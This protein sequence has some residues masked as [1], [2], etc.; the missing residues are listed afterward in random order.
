MCIRD[1]YQRRVRDTF[2]SSMARQL[3][4]IIDV[5]DLTG[6]VAIITGA[7]RGIGREVALALAQRGCNIVV[8]AKTT[9]PQPTLPG[10]IYS[11]AAEV[12]KLGVQALA[13]KVNLRDLDTIKKC[14]EDT[15]AKF[16]RI[17]ILVNNASA[18]WW[19]DIVD[20]PVNKYDLITSINARG[21]FF[22]T[23]GVLPHMKRNGFG[24]IVN[25]SP[26]IT[27]NTMGGHTAYNISKLGMTMVALGVSQEFGPES[28]ITA[29][30][31]W[32]ATVVE[33]YAS[34]NFKLGDPELWR[35]ATIMSD[36]VLAIVSEPHTFS[37]NELIDDTY[38]LT[39]GFT[40]E[41]LVQYRYD[42]NV[43]PPRALDPHGPTQDY[44]YKGA[45]K[46]GDVKKLDKDIDQSS[47]KP[48]NP[49]K[50]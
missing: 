7:T 44:D 12:E 13:C 46:R 22:M 1:R 19:Q 15:V 49:S 14:V 30:T 27:T 8:A 25:T 29:N 20:T 23:Q 6:R 34:I 28:G 11:V 35:K 38:L 2:R 47:Y 31:L 26:P 48:L 50:L 16:G 5:A 41:D 42:P 10:T 24:R 17:D 36:C 33:S 37:G 21:T 9:E 18:L 43:E 32:P 4:E 39:R 40:Q 3:S 45:A